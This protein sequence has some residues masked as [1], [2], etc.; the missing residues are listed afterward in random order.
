MDIF[1][2]AYIARQ[3]ITASLMVGAIVV[4]TLSSR[5]ESTVSI[6]LT[7]DCRAP[8]SLFM[9]LSLSLSYHAQLRE[10]DRVT[11][12]S[13]PYTTWLGGLTFFFEAM[14]V[15][16]RISSGSGNGGQQDQELVEALDAGDLLWS[17]AVWVLW[18]GEQF[19]GHLGRGREKGS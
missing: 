17:A 6:T 3:A 13:F 1:P 16:V 19:G 15:L 14:L 7:N 9:P 8:L 11:T 4:T 2:G 18:L 10:V 12:S 5:V